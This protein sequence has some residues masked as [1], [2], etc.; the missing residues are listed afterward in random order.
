MAFCDRTVAFR[1]LPIGGEGDN[2]EEGKDAREAR[3]VAMSVTPEW[4]STY[5]ELLPA[6]EVMRSQCRELDQLHRKILDVVFDELTS[7]RLEAQRTHLE[8]TIQGSLTTARQRQL[9]LLT[10]TEARL[11][12]TE[13]LQR[14]VLSAVI[15]RLGAEL[16]GLVVEF[17]SVQA[18]FKARLESQSRIARAAHKRNNGHEEQEEEEE[19]AVIDDD[20]LLLVH[21]QDKE[22]KRHHER[23]RNRAIVKITQ[24]ISE[25][26]M[27]GIQI[28][29]TIAEQGSMLD[30]IDTHLVQVRDRV[31]RGRAALVA[32]DQ[33]S[34]KSGR[35]W[36]G[37]CGGWLVALLIVLLVFIWR[38]S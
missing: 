3:H 29:T 17:Q 19:E 7:K 13:V 1:R 35:L 25:L 22:Q 28:D 15:R 14:Q 5:Q 27:L 2:E 36:L 32:A 33:H 6:F 16:Q 21:D 4:F 20:S 37:C 24:S 8:A 10:H 12:E 11:H 26:H 31:G 23:A 30:R 38:H 18:T 34:A 9:E